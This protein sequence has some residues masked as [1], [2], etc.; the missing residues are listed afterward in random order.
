MAG[1][2]WEMLVQTKQQACI[3]NIHKSA[4]FAVILLKRRNNLQYKCYKVKLQSVPS[5]SP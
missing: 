1:K 2:N 5:Q 4:D 3:Q